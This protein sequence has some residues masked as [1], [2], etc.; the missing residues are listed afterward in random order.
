MSTRLSSLNDKQNSLLNQLAYIDGIVDWS[1]GETIVEVLR[2][3]DKEDLFREFM[4]W[5]LGDLTMVGLKNDNANTGFCAIAFATPSGEVGMSFRGTEFDKGPKDMLDNISTA[6]IGTSPQ[7]ALAS[8]FYNAHKD[9]AGNNYLYGH[10]KGGNL[11]MEVFATNYLEIK[12]VYVIN[13]QPINP[14]GL[15]PDQLAALLRVNAIVIDG[16]VVSGLGANSI[17]PARYVKNNGSKD[18]DFF[19]PH[20]IESMEFDEFGNAKPESHPFEKYPLQK[21]A[22]IAASNIIGAVQGWLA[23]FS[24]AVNVAERV[25][26]FFANDLPD[27][28]E[29]FYAWA[30]GAVDDIKEW[31]KNVKDAVK[32]FIAKCKDGISDWWNKTFNAGY[33]YAMANPL[34][35][36]DTYK[37]KTYAQR[38]DGVNQRLNWLDT[39]IDALYWQVGLFDLWDL[40]KSD[41][42]IGKS[43]RVS[44]AAEYLRDTAAELEKFENEIV[45]RLSC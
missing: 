3:A 34:M 27:M 15:F 36:V 44:R 8:A 9:K 31:A 20:C 42:K 13:A 25:Y 39:R 2:R 29:K 28:A 40:I 6:A 30:S 16:D 33:K 7:A 18:D 5:G 26:D 11:A 14:F 1:K 38:L 17:P 10:S 23:P 12:G 22:R 41:W 45:G 43:L 4:A 35:L 37:L 32:D 21:A 24:W 19:G